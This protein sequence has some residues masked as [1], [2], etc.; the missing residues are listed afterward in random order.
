MIG[1]N[2]SKSIFTRF[3]RLCVWRGIREAAK[4]VS[5]FAKILFYYTAM[6]ELW[7]ANFFFS[8]IVYDG[9]TIEYKA[10][11]GDFSIQFQS[12]KGGGKGEDKWIT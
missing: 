1:L 6:V 8:I 10:I 4:Q 7:T 12:L 11:G 3:I 9:P 2:G 5:Q